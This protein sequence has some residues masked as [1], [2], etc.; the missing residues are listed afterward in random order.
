MVFFRLPTVLFITLVFW[1]T[2]H[3]STLSVGLKV[4]NTASPKV[5]GWF[6]I[7]VTEWVS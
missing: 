7:R 2:L 5:N 4:F 6:L 1:K 3:N